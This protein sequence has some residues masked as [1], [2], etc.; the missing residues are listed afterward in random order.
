MD[1]SSHVWSLHH[2]YVSL[3]AA[4]DR[5]A[6]GLC[7]HRLSDDDLGYTLEPRKYTLW[8][9]LCFCISGLCKV[10]TILQR[11]IRKTMQVINQISAQYQ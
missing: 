2:F 11:V 8:I 3:T 1:T 10:Y 7:A 9:L 5:E 6:L 4:L